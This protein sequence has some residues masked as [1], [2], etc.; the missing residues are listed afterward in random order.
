MNKTK[1]RKTNTSHSRHNTNYMWIIGVLR[2]QREI[3]PEEEFEEIMAKIFPKLM[4][5][6]KLSFNK[7]MNHKKD[8]TKNF[9]LNTS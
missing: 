7:C 9:M 2:E 8:N 4:K 3:G 5:H 1:S 6:M